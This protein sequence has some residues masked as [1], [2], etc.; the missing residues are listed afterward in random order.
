MTHT[1]LLFTT[2]S[3][4]EAANNTIWQYGVALAQA[5]GYQ[6]NVESGI[7]GKRNGID[8]PAGAKTLCW[9]KPPLTQILDGRW[10]VS[11]PNRHP[12]A[13][14]PAKLAAIMS[15]LSGYTEGSDDGTWYPPE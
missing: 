4:A 14:D 11:H 13:K 6:A 3:E 1:H 10:I 5:A 8:D 9:D 15:Q 12:A 2:E 7:T